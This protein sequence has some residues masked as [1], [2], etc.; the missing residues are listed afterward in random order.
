M[1][2]A[3]DLQY[4]RKDLALNEGCKMALPYSGV[5]AHLN[6]QTSRESQVGMLE[7]LVRLVEI[8]EST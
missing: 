1:H 3:P 6:D 4:I 7:G 2:L 8:K 5:E